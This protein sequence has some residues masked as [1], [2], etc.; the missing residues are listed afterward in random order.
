MRIWIF[1]FYLHNTPHQ[2]RCK[3]RTELSAD[4]I[5]GTSPAVCHELLMQCSTSCWLTKVREVEVGSC[6]LLL[7]MH[8]GPSKACPHALSV[9][10]QVTA[11]RSW[12]FPSRLQTTLSIVEHFYLDDIFLLYFVSLQIKALILYHLL[13]DYHNNIH[14]FSSI[15]ISVLYKYWPTE[16]KRQKKAHCLP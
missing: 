13:Q 11:K 16:F 3:Q 6:Q 4:V 7:H 9:G 1:S 2:E 10:C 8:P 5:P 14:I 12:V 15:N